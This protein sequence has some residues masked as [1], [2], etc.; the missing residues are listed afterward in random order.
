MSKSNEIYRCSKCGNLIEVLVGGSCTPVCCGEE[1]TLLKE[2]TSDG[3][4][5]K[6]VPVIEKID[7]GYKVSV[8]SVAHPMTPAH[9]IQFIEL[10]CEGGEVLRK[11]LTPEDKPV[12]VF[13]TDSAALYAREYC[14][15]HGL[16][17]G[18]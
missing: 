1:M 5:E 4:R 9:Y 10:V 7:G 11:S 14:N 12:A 15:L 17:K 3:A 13:K 8:G 18:E 2:N 6:H 16:W